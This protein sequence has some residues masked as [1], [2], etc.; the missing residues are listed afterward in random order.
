MSA[1]IA[2]L[3]RHPVKSLGEEALEAVTLTA[4]RHMPWDRIWALT[5]AGSTFDPAAGTWRSSRDF[6]IQSLIPEFARIR[7]SFDDEA[8]LLRLDHP[9]RSRL[10]VRPEEAEAEARLG[11]WLQP[12]VG[13][14]L[15]PPFRLVR[16]PGQPLT[17]FPHTHLLICSTASRAAL[18]EIAGRPLADIR[19]RANVWLDGLPPW[20]EAELIGTEITLGEARVRIVEHCTRCN[21]TAA[22]PDTGERDVPVPGLL[23][24][25]FGHMDF[26]VYGQVVGGGRVTIGDPAVL[27]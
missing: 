7:A 12:L 5:H 11:V 19:F 16:L 22:S 26:G 3:Y 10:E 14:R 24:R 18:E 4:G 27:A 2:R 1:T 15:D 17:D 20:R 6:V 9:S 8:G 21:A 23:R 13:D 25:Q